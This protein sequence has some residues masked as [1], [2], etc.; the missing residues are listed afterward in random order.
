VQQHSTSIR[1]IAL[2]DV[3]SA[4]FIEGLIS[5]LIAFLSLDY[6]VAKYFFI[7]IKLYKSLKSATK[8]LREFFARVFFFFFNFNLV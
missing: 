6:R 4:L 2:V 7:A 5:L 3:I 8:P 1:V